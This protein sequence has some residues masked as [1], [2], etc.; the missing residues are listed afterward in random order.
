MIRQN[1]KEIHADKIKII[2]EPKNFEAVGNV[3]T[4]IKDIGSS[5]NGKDGGL[6]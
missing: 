3:R 4:I 2:V 1:E 6:L 5:K